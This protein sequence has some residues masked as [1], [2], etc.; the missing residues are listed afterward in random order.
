[1]KKDYWIRFFH[2]SSIRSIKTMAQTAVSMIAVGAALKDIDFVTL[3]S[4]TIV[5]GLLSYLTSLATGLPEMELPEYPDD[6]E[7]DAGE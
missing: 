2:A 4:V 7:S 3:G 1:M 5:S 6:G